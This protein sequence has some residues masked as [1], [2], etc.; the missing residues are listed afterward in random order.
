MK[1]GDEI[2]DKHKTDFHIV[3]NRFFMFFAAVPS[4][5]SYCYTDN[6]RRGA[7]PVKHIVRRLFRRRS[8]LPGKHR[9]ILQTV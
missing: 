9:K 7:W 8:F 4:Y 6:Y 1:I 2:S 3:R 5:Y